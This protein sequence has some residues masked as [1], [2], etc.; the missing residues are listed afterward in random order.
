MLPEDEAR[1]TDVSEP[2]T[3]PRIRAEFKL[4]RGSDCGC[5]LVELFP[6]A[7]EYD[8]QVVGDTCFVNVFVGTHGGADSPTAVQHTRELQSGCPCVVFARHDCIPRFQRVSEDAV[9]MVTYLPDRERLSEL[10]ADL[11]ES[12]PSVSL[13]RIARAND[14]DSGRRRFLDLTVLDMSVLTPTERET[15][16][17]AS[18]AGY[19]EHPRETT[20][21][22]LA[23]EFDVTNQALSQRLQS[24][25]SKLAKQLFRGE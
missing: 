16:E 23:D 7:E 14:D 10:V 25:E 6:D 4:G 1:E 18:A 13:N 9:F 15:M 11:R 20:L 8:R 3:R 12:V 5:P 2:P 24:A 17:R 19:F 21:A 22:E